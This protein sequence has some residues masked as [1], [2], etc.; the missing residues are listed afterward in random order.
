MTTTISIAD[1]LTKA[2]FIY[3]Y[4]PV[5]EE[6]IAPSYGHV[7]AMTLREALGGV[8]YAENI[9]FISIDLPIEKDQHII[10]DEKGD[11]FID[12]TDGTVTKRIAVKKAPV[13]HID[14]E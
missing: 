11:W 3:S 2:K 7:S 10:V 9:L 6:K 1:L 5:D 4:V 14:E 12:L 8:L 13:M